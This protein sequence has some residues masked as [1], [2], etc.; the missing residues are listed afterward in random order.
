MFKTIAEKIPRDRD[1]PLRQWTNDVLTR[2]L[3]GTFYD[4]LSFDFHQ[5]RKEGIGEYIPLRDRRPSVRYALCRIVVEDSVAMLFSEGHFPSVQCEDENNAAALMAI[6]KDSK[7]NQLMIEAST[8]GSVGSVAI[9]MRVLKNRVFFEAKSTAFLTPIWRDDAP[10]TLVQVVEKYKV[11]GDVLKDSGYAIDVDDLKSWFWFQRI[12]DTSAETWFTP[13]KVNGNADD[14]TFVD[15][16]KTT[17]HNLG[18][19]PIVWVRNLPGGDDIDGKP[20]F[21]TEVI[22]TQIEIDYQLSQAGRGLKYSSDPTLMIKEPAVDNDGKLIKGG[23]NAIVVDAD[24]DVK[25]LEINGTA[26]DAVLNYVRAL[27]E[28]GL[29][30]AHGNRVSADKISAAQ[31]GRAME[32]M[33]QALIWLSDKLRISYGEGALLELLTMIANAQQVFKLVNKIGEQYPQMDATKPLTLRWPAWYAPTYID[34]QAEATTL[35]I[36]YEAHLISQETAVGTVSQSYDVED[37]IEELR[38]IK[39]DEAEELKNIKP[40]MV[41]Q[42]VFR[43]ANQMIVASN[44]ES[45]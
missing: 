24:G 37:T 21:S 28:F 19:V 5:E 3:D 6:I 36:L 23:G 9:L 8:K 30:S 1:Y 4:H 38:K 13:W 29:E 43:D 2:V 22:D 26:A 15:S 7:L 25:M 31:S 33:N 35:N 40:K 32:L 10:D 14:K 16:T 27:R 17:T 12:W 34:K 11:Q 20:T 42:T 39:L 41:K 44:E 45:T 18:F